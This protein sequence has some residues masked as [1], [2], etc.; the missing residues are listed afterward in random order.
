VT[1]GARLSDTGGTARL[2]RAGVDAQARMN[3]E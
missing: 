1:G 2:A 3:L